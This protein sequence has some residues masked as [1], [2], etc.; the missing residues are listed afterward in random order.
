MFLFWV[1]FVGYKKTANKEKKESLWIFS[2]CLGIW[3]QLCGNEVACQAVM[4]MSNNHR[5][6]KLGSSLSF[7]PGDE[8]AVYLSGPHRQSSAPQRTV[9]KGRRK[10]KSNKQWQTRVGLAGIVL[11]HHWR[12]G[13]FHANSHRNICPAIIMGHRCHHYT[14]LSPITSSPL[15]ALLSPSPSLPLKLCQ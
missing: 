9:C 11:M 12:A 4:E 6:Q 3:H 10:K 15:T 8:S 13:C 14:L 2:W 1:S 7:I 5:P